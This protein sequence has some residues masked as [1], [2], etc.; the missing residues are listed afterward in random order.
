MNNIVIGK[1]VTLGAV[2]NSCA[3][4]AAHF[5]PDHA[6]AIVAAAVPI[7]F[8]A[9]VIVGNKFGITTGEQDNG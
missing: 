5:F 3:A 4:V 8:V 6:P 1:R 9:Q 7:T 2:I